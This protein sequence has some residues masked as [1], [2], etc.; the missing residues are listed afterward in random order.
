[1][2]SEND[3]EEAIL[4]R[5]FDEWSFRA[6]TILVPLVIAIVGW[7]FALSARIEAIATKQ[8]ERGPKIASLEHQI[9]VLE[10]IARDPSPRPE[11][12]IA[13]AAIKADHDKMDERVT[14]LEDRVNNLH[15]YMMALPVRPSPA[16]YAPPS[17]RGEADLKQWLEKQL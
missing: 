9:E 16:P 8:E 17:K 10:Q 6:I 11:A 15:N 5:R 13:I 1:M 3:H 7:S 2:S 4:R 14:R 12:K